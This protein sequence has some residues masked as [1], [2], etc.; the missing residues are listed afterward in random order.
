MGNSGKLF[1]VI[2]DGVA[3]IDLVRTTCNGEYD[4]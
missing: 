3:C 4:I 1:A 2:A